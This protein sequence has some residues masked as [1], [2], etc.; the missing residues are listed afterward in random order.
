M[1]SRPDKLDLQDEFGLHDVVWRP[2]L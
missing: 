2:L 1:S